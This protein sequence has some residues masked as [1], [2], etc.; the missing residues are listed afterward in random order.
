VNVDQLQNLAFILLVFV[1][2]IAVLTRR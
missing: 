1:L 2:I